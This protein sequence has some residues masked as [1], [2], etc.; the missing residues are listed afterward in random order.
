MYL[1][2]ECTRQSEVS[3]PGMLFQVDSGGSTDAGVDNSDLN[4]RAGPCSQVHMVQAVAC[5]HGRPICLSD[6]SV[7]GSILR[8]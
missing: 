7:S 5:L 4:L 2:Q 3:A 8:G 6:T 1:P